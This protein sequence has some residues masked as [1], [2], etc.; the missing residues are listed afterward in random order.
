MAFP[1]AVARLLGAA[2][3]RPERSV[4]ATAAA[5]SAWVLVSVVA[6]SASP[7]GLG[8]LHERSLFFLAPLV[9]ACLA[10]WLGHGLPRRRAVAALSAV[11]VVA[12]IAALPE[13]FVE[14]SNVFDYPALRPV[15]VLL[16]HHPSIPPTCG[17]WAPRCSPPRIFL[18]ARSR[19]RRIACVVVAFVALA[20]TVSWPDAVSTAEAPPRVGRRGAAGIRAGAARARR[21]APR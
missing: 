3:P 16:E 7:Y 1:V 4:G 2:R 9:L 18:A 11:A 20:G 19:S 15:A 13:R 5:I 6:L 21:P 10:H 12:A 8:F 14:R 17:S